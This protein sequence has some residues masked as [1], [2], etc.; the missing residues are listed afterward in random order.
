MIFS[1]DKLIKLIKFVLKL[2][3]SERTGVEIQVL[4]KKNQRLL[5]T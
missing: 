2:I 4:T 1:D 5:L 3:S